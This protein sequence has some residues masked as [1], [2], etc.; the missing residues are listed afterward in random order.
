MQGRPVSASEKILH[1]RIAQLGCIACRIE[2]RFNPHVSIHHVH[3]RTQPGCHM[4][5]LPLCAPHHQDDGTVL[6]VHPWKTR[7]ENKYGKQDDL[8]AEQWAS[9]GV[10]YSPAERKQRKASVQQAQKTKPK[11][12]AIPDD[13][14]NVKSKPVKAKLPQRTPAPKPVVTAQQA[15]FIQ[16]RKAEQKAA[17]SDMRAEQKERVKIYAAQKK[18]EYLEANKELILERKSLAKAEQKRIKAEF[19]KQMKIAG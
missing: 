3:G 15:A 1:D 7:W 9:L 16:K 8:V 11:A 17:T 12:K 14:H 4:H 6:A 18:A 5:V 13:A 2:G 19:A 10:E